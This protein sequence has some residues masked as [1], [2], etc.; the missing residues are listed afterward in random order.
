M[1]VRGLL[2]LSC[3]TALGLIERK[4]DLARA[5]P[6]RPPGRLVVLAA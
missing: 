5:Y 2:R 4:L 1:C 6:G 3:N